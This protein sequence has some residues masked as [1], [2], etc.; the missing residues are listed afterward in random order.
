MARAGCDGIVAS[1][2][3]VT[4]GWEAISASICPDPTWETLANAFLR[5]IAEAE[6][7]SIEYTSLN[8][9]KLTGW[10]MLP[11]G[12]QPG[13]RYPLLTWV[14]AGSVYPDKPPGYMG[15]DSLL[16]LN[17][18]IAAAHGYVVL[19]PSMPLAPE[20]V[21]DDPMLRLPAG[22]LPAVGTRLCGGARLCGRAFQIVRPGSIER[23]L[24]GAD[25]CDGTVAGMGEHC[26][27][28]TF[29]HRYR[30][31]DRGKEGRTLGAEK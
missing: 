13:H 21:T 23:F 16:Y 7:K 24:D 9:A 22:V 28:Q 20:G 5:D 29:D 12:Y 14:Y 25:A 6:Y 3:S 4:A 31:R 17:L 1:D 8:G 11:Y 30:R 27:R 10:L 26:R 18:Q 15:I 19:F 2:V